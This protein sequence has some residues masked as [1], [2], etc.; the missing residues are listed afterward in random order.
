MSI[1]RPERDELRRLNNAY[2]FTERIGNRYYPDKRCEVCKAPSHGT[3]ICSKCLR[4]LNE[5][6]AKYRG[7]I[8]CDLCKLEVREV[9][10]CDEDDFIILDCMSCHVPMIVTKTHLMNADADL[11]DRML[12]ALDAIAEDKYG[13]GN[14]KITTNQQ[15]VLDHLHWHARP[16]KNES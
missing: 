15:R 12:F 13:P 3:G 14:Y 7:Q 16:I 1:T 8:D 9:V 4:R 10:Y 5:L 2:H 11:K 6:E